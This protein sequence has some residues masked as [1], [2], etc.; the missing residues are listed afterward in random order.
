MSLVGPR[1]EVP[2][3]V[4]KYSQSQRRVLDL[5]PGITDEASIVF[6]NEEALLAR[7]SDPEAFYLEHCLPR[8]IELNLQY[9]QRA[10]L[11]R[12]VLIILRTIRSLWQSAGSPTT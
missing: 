5:K 12:D 10:S 6:R 8:K 11:W 7:A 2:E 9:A 1:P 3:Y 4:A